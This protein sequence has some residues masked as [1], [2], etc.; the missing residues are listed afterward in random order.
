MIYIKK[1]IEN[2]ETHS[3]IGSTKLKYNGND[4]YKVLLLHLDQS[5]DP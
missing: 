2:F 4:I 1:A 5:Y 3:K